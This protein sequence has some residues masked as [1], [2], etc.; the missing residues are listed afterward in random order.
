MSGAGSKYDAVVVG[1][2]PNGLSAAIVMAQAGRSVLVIE[3][4]DRIG[5]G[6]RSAEVTLPGYVHDICAAIHPTGV[7]SPFLSTLPLADHGLDWVFP[8]V[9][10]AQPLDDGTAGLLVRSVDETAA[11]L[12]E[13]GPAWK[14]LM[15]PLAAEW[16]GLYEELLGPLQVPPRHPLLLTRFGLRAMRSALGLAGGLFRTAR[17]RALF[18]GCAA[19]ATLPLDKPFTAAFGLVLA[20]A[21]H[22]VGWPCARGGSQRIVEAMASY[23][24]SLGGEIVTGR[25]IGHLRELPESQVVLFDVGPAQLLRIAG[26]A[27]PSSYR[28]RLNRYRYGP[29]SFKVDYALDGPIP[30]KSPDC[31]R[32]GTV[33]LGGTIEEMAVSEAA[34]WRGELSEKP[35]VLVAQQSLFDPSR[36]PAGHFTGWAYCHVPA[37][38]TIDATAAIEAQIERFAPG[39]RDRILARHVTTPRAFEQYNENYIGGDISGG[40]ADITQLFTRPVARVVPYSTPNPKIYL[41][42][43]STPPGAGVHGMCGYHAARA[44][45]RRAFGQRIAFPPPGKRHL[46]P[47]K[48][49]QV[50][51]Q[52]APALP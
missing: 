44:A 39:F 2:G 48:P 31:A 25:R 51:S 32:A 23:L 29:A 22:A 35:Y 16:E 11:S 13:D 45:L 9:A 30:W 42:S 38:S 28:W 8:P 3:A 34:I 43:S 5:G 26:D 12:G 37:G 47:S 40:V 33:H 18:G 7:V 21:G 41:C 19:H 24:R 1:A 20:V 36:A 10:F 15:A 17:A 4:N 6:S 50:P 49:A 27:L 46:L 52:V 14:R